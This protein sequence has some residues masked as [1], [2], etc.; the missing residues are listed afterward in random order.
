MPKHVI[1]V[2]LST[3]RLAQLDQTA[4][5]LGM[6]RSQAIDAALRILPDLVSGT[7]E[8]KLDP[9]RLGERLPGGANRRGS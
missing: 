7:C 6:N 9:A 4:L 5:R 1:S 3:E 2:R 8:L